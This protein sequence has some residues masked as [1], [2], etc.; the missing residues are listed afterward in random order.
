ME[1][2]A[3]MSMRKASDWLL[4]VV[5]QNTTTLLSKPKILLSLICGESLK[6]RL[7]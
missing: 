2:T 7:V 4:V 1:V 5:Q 6:V 3:Q